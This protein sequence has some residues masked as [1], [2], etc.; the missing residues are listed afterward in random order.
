LHQKD[1]EFA[2]RSF[3]RLMGGTLGASCL[4]LNWSEVAVAARQAAS[5]IASGSD[6]MQFLTA[7][8]AADV[9]AICAQIIPTDSTPGA[10]EA[11]VLLFVDRAL[12]SF[13]APQAVM[14]RSGLA[15]FQ[16]A[17]L[18]WRPQAGSF[19]GLSSAQQIEFLHTVDHTPFFDLMRQLTVIGMFSLP[20]YG[21]NRN[22]A[23]WTLLGFEDVHAFQP[24]F[25]YYDRDYPGFRDEPLKPA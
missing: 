17:C 7:G 9:G 12:A 4:A 13:Y 5:D 1:A 11:G 24:P 22:G 15:E 3:L 20:M 8:E 16:G 2:R 14:F 25:G 6:A 18:K 10:R 21:G 23:G 19:S